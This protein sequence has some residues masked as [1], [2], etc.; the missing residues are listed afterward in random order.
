MLCI[1]PLLNMSPETNVQSYPYIH[2]YL[3]MVLHINITCIN[4]DM[5][6]H[7]YLTYCYPCDEHTPPNVHLDLDFIVSH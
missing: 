1:Y 3:Y 5:Y 4:K 7:V 2:A 6:V